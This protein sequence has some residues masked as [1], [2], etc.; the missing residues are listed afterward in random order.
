MGT[1]KLRISQCMIVK[2]EEKNIERALS[3]GKEL[4]WEQIV[5]DTGSTDRTVEIAERMGAKIYYFTWIDDFSAAKNFAI[6][7]ASGDW[8]AFL[9]AD[10]YMLPDDLYKLPAMIKKAKKQGKEILRTLWLQMGDEQALNMVASQCRIF[11]NIPQI[12]Y[13]NPIHEELCYNGG[14]DGICEMDA[15]SLSI[16]HTGYTTEL[17][18]QKSKR[19]IRILLKELEKCPEDPN[20][21]GYLGDAYRGLEGKKE[22][23][24]RWYRKALPYI[25]QKRL[26]SERDFYTIVSLMLYFYERGSEAEQELMELYENA[27][28]FAGFYDADY[29]VGWFY[30]KRR[31]FQKGEY[32]LERA[33]RMMEQYGTA[34]FNPMAT[35]DLPNTWRTLALCYYMNGKL[36]KSVNCCVN[37]LTADKTHAGTLEVLLRCFKDEESQAVVSFLQKLYNINDIS[38]RVV[39]LSGAM[40][41]GEA[42]AGVLNVLRQYCTEEELEVLEKRTGNSMDVDEDDA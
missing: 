36:E 4:M 28:T 23:A 8:I 9:D 40:R 35:R 17:S 21:M 11:K 19:N 27:S 25:F 2:N 1:G 20:I 13:Q 42:G 7:Q 22:E 12:R 41:A 38:D 31:D 33:L 30:A 16:Y 6:E 39:M 15:T 34:T 14:I 18:E 3:W 5:V 29:I 26:G 10:E 24:E 32:Y 37:L